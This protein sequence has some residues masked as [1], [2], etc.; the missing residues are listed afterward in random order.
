[1]NLK[2]ARRVS[3]AIFVGGMRPDSKRLPHDRG[4]LVSKILPAQDDNSDLRNG[5]VMLVLPI[6]LWH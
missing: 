3:R 2:I 6:Y 1:M 5:Q 4:K